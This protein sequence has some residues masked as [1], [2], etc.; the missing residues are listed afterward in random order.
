MKR[1]INIIVSILCLVF[2]FLIIGSQGNEYHYCQ[3]TEVLLLLF[4]F[5]YNK[6]YSNL[7]SSLRRFEVKLQA[8]FVLCSFIVL[9]KVHFEHPTSTNSMLSL[10]LLLMALVL[11][12]VDFG[13]TPVRQ[14][15]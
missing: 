1:N 15:S 13:I 7:M 11:A 3:I 14:D 9:I 12:I 4:Y 2:V 8:S 6:R 10:V 5:L